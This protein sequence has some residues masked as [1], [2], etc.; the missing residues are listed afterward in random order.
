LKNKHPR[1][2]YFCSWLTKPN[3]KLVKDTE[4]IIALLEDISD[5]FPTLPY[6]IA[7]WRIKN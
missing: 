7:M 2:T 6:L 4:Q 3:W 5:L 1:G